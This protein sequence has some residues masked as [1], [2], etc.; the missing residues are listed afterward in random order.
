[1]STFE[2]WSDVMYAVTANTGIDMQPVQG[3]QIY[4]V[5][6][7]LV[8]MLVCGFLALNLFVGVL[9]D[10]YSRISQRRGASAFL[11]EEQIQWVR[12]QEVLL[13]LRPLLRVTEPTNP[14]LGCV[15]QV[16]NSGY[17][18]AIEFGVLLSGVIATSCVNFGQ[19]DNATNSIFVINGFCS[20]FAIINMGVTVIT[21]R[22]R[23]FTGYYNRFDLAMCVVG[24]LMFLIN[25]GSDRT[26]PAVPL[27][28]IRL[29]R[30]PRVWEILDNS[31][32]EFVQG[33]SASYVLLY[34][35]FFRH[36]SLIVVLILGPMNVM[37]TLLVTLPGIFNV[38]CVLFL[39][40]FIY[41]TMG[42]QIFAKVAYYGA[43]N[44][45]ANFRSFWVAF[46]TMF[47]FGTVNNW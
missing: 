46:Q 43:Y 24:D 22:K 5:Y 21:S 8:L 32:L 17:F 23:F 42:M 18:L 2:N 10:N 3:N 12:T 38:A 14:A 15:Y 39:L 44:D 29:L 28:I 19:S 33:N 26:F 31:N 1:M 37:R 36:L 9:C 20:I 30:L 41:T 16:R 6:F 13:H 40:L 45:N 11:T 27:G 25:T 47:Q 4:W 34:F 7:F 35:Y